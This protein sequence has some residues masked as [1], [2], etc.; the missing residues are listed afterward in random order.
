MSHHPTEAL[1]NH[2]SLCDE[3]HQLALEENRFLK[4]HQRTPDAA[5]LDRKR[6]LLAKLDASLTE[7]KSSGASTPPGRPDPERKE[8][9]EK[10]RAKILQILHLDRENEQLLLRHSLG[11]RPIAPATPP[12]APSV[13]HL[14]RLYE[15]HS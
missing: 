11:T 4:Q 10:A 12:P 2:L 6:A 13:S 14:Q 5:L 7:L 3:I 15:R 1:K 8:I 9:I